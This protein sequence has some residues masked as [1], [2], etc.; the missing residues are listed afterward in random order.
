MAGRGSKQDGN[1]DGNQDGGQRGGSASGWE[2]G[3]R[4]GQGSRR[5]DLGFGSDDDGAADGGFG[6]EL[7]AFN[8]AD[9]QPRRPRRGK[10]PGEGAGSVTEIAAEK[11]GFRSREPVQPTWQKPPARK[12]EAVKPDA[13]KQNLAKQNLAKPDPVKQAPPEQAPRPLRRRRTGRN[14]QFNIKAK[15]ETIDAFCAIADARG[16]GLGE[17]L[18]KAVAL[19]Q[20]TWPG[21]A[22]PDTGPDTG[23]NSGLKSAPKTS[24]DGGPD[25]R[26][27]SSR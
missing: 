19:M 9:W 3:Q 18:E 16:W 26:R 4:G 10:T 11:A 27:K 12:P 21:D 8:P 20:Q 25:N 22:V 23:L 24:L 13:A 1:Q 17:T 14:A 5:P 2:G 7:D 6:T 15:P